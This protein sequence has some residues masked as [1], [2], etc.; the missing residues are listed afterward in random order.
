MV[1]NHFENI[2]E[3]DFKSFEI[4]RNFYDGWIF[5]LLPRLEWPSYRAVLLTRQGRT[6]TN[7]SSE[8]VSFLFEHKINT[9]EAV[10]VYILAVHP[11]FT[12]G[13]SVFFQSSDNLLLVIKA[14]RKPPYVF[15]LFVLFVYL[16]FNRMLLSLN[17]N[18]SQNKC[19]EQPVLWRLELRQLITI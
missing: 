7:R 5:I 16:F 18:I 17:R 2:Y 12:R 1:V 9:V 10:V 14:M 6:G 4:N 8:D 3:S 15:C 13:L 11:S 19:M